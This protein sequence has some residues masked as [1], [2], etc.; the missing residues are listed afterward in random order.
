MET[1]CAIA[2]RACDAFTNSVV[3][4]ITFTRLY[5]IAGSNEIVYEG[6]QWTKFEYKVDPDF[7]TPNIKG[8]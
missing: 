6:G 8:K 5:T 4:A 2:V 1:V 7:L 3:L